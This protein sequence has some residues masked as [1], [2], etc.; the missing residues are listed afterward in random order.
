MTYDKVKY[1][2]EYN[3]NA[4]KVVK[5]YIQIND[6]ESI[7]EHAKKRGYEKMSGYI[8]ALIDTDMG[9]KDPPADSQGEG[10]GI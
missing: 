9:K 8:K 10:E 6:Y 7:V 1:N 2:N 3:K 4:Y 5:V